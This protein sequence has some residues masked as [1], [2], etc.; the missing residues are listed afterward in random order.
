MKSLYLMVVHSKQI[1]IPTNV[2]VLSNPAYEKELAEELKTCNK[3]GDVK[4]RITKIA[5][6]H[7]K[8]ITMEQVFLSDNKNHNKSSSACIIIDVDANKVV[9]N[10]FDK[11]QEEYI[12]RYY[13]EKYEDKILEFNSKFRKNNG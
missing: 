3:K 9:K 8:E 1:Q 5:H 2:E 13:L 12:L 10:R 7:K 4:K 11:S 6:R